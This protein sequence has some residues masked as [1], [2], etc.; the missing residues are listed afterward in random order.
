MWQRVL[1]VF[2]KEVMDNARDR[3]SLLIALIYPLLGPLI[4]GLMIVAVGKATVSGGG[5]A[6]SLAVKG[7]ENGPM[8]V[9]WLAQKGVEVVPAPA[10]VEAAVKDGSVEV[11]L[12]IPAGF[13][14]EM[15]AETT[16]RLTIVVNTSRLSGFVSVNRVA[17][18]LGVFNN[19]IWG[20][21]IASRG[22]AFRALQPIEIDNINVTSG[23]QIADILL[24]MVP[25]LFIFNLF[26]GGVYLA[27]DTT[28]GERERGS[29]EPLLIN[30]IER[31]AL[32]FGKFLAALLYT[33]IAVVVQLLALKFAFHM[34]G[35]EGSNFTYTLGMRTILGIILVMLPLMMAAVAV[36]FIIATIT[37]SFKE[38]QTYLGLLPLIPAIPGMVLVFAPVQANTWM[39]TIPTFSQTLLLGQILRGDTL[40]AAHV[41]ISLL[42]T[43]AFACALIAIAV[44]LYEREELIFGG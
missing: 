43:L 42:A 20:Q 33:G 25:P 18:L 13:T 34:A 32:V 1:I 26:M 15:A 16:T 36:Q 14:T 37:R 12:V 41:A 3:R 11:V 29:L 28:S 6:M 21:R 30:P 31:S 17:S 44:R 35:G 40:V 4:M 5:Q 23:A 24:F 39:M 2:K 8:L 38:A 22:V 10:D 7:I 19:E 9:D 27:I